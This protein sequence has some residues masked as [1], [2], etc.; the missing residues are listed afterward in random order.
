MSSFELQAPTNLYKKRD[1]AAGA[2][3]VYTMNS[4][5]TS[6]RELQGSGWYHSHLS[7]LYRRSQL[8]AGIPERVADSMLQAPSQIGL[9]CS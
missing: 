2:F 6:A 8:P 4:E 7:A 1:T 9:T 3:S 5:L